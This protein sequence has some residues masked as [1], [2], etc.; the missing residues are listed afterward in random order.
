MSRI[1]DLN[2]ILELEKEI[3]DLES[4]QLNNIQLSTEE[5]AKLI[6]L[7]HQ[8]RKILDEEYKLRQK[9]RTL[10]EGIFNML[11][12]NLKTSENTLKME[13]AQKTIRSSLAQEI[14]KFREYESKGLTEKAKE[15]KKIIDQLKEQVNLNQASIAAMGRSVIGGHKFA[16]AIGITSSAVKGISEGFSVIFTV[17]SGIYEFVSKIWT[18]FD[19]VDHAVRDISVNM[20]LTNAQMESFSKNTANAAIDA[21]KLGMGVEDVIKLQQTMGEGLGRNLVLTREQIKGVAE[22]AQGTNLGVDGVSTMGEAFDSFGVNLD[23]MRGRVESV[24]KSTQ[25]IGLNSS[26]VFKIISDNLKT[27][28]KFNFK[29]GTKGLESMARKSASIKMDLGGVF[30]LAEKLFDVEGAVD[31]SAELQVLGGSFAKLSDPFQLMFQARNDVDGLTDSLIEATKN[32]AVFDKATGEFKIP[33]MELHRLRK[34]ADATGISLENLTEPALQL[35]KQGRAMSQLS[36]AFKYTPEQRQAIAN[37]AQVGSNG[38]LE[39]VTSDGTKQALS[40]L[41][42]TEIEKV[43]G[44]T[45]S[46]EQA[47]KS[48]MTFLDMLKNIGNVFSSKL[49]PVLESISR[50]LLDGGLLDKLQ[51]VAD[52]IGGF[53][54]ELFTNDKVDK[55]IEGTKTFIDSIMKMIND[56]LSGNSSFSTKIIKIG[57]N[58]IA[59]MFKEAVNMFMKPLLGGLGGAAL[60]GLVGGAFGGPAGAMAGA[61]FGGLAG[62]A[63]GGAMMINDGQVLPNSKVISQVT[64]SGGLKPLAITNPLDT[65]TAT[66]SGGYGSMNATINFGV[67]RVDL[68]MGASKDIRL[69]LINDAEFMRQITSGVKQKTIQLMN[70]TA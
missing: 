18:D 10:N 59:S 27:A 57:G 8:E 30:G 2:K 52:K 34:V 64:P 60:G 39:I 4:K 33:A 38:V 6:E 22:M 45:S 51:T 65:I 53:L 23:T 70:G 40:S 12:A 31:L 1:R 67:L 63:L 24:F 36:N 21:A 28:Q 3:A 58:I 17:I 55:L 26:K 20:G 25:K 41:N 49:F 43:L 35:A 50:K 66:K 42:P 19:K 11:K 5:T 29:D 69:A 9:T 56:V 44:K 54:S 37:L 47:A 46:L 7:Y 61:H 68:G 13:K 48:R 62:T 32:V 15:Q 14:K 16:K